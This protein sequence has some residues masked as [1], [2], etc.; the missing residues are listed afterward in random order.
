MIDVYSWPTPNGRKIHIMLE[1]C[2][3]EYNAHP[4]NIGKGEQFEPDFL[5]I[6][7]NNRIPAITDS[8]GPDGKPISLFESGAI[9][10]YLADKT[11]QFLPTEPRAK[12]ETLQWL[13]FQMGGVGPMFGQSNH[14]S[15][16]AVDKIPYAI[17]RYVNECKRLYGVMD[18]RLGEVDYLA[19]ADYTIAD[20]ATH[21]WAQGYERRGVDINDYPN[22]KRWVEVIHERPA[23][24]RGVEVLAQ[25]RSSGNFTA[26]EREV[27]FG[28]TQFEKR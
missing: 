17:D 19:G 25:E 24:I 16:Y 9:L 14:F 28:K 10:I 13:M 18:T 11:G 2:G 4:V 8:D 7:P 5:K 15:H 6:S 3:L 22:V 20:I 26:E 12:Y 21:P 27:L 23:V 1:E